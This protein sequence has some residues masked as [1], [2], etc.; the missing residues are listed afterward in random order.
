M[1]RIPAKV[2]QFGPTIAAA[3]GLLIL[4]GCG[5]MYPAT[6]QAPAPVAYN[7]PS[8]ALTNLPASEVNRY[9]VNFATGSDQIGAS[10]MSAINGAA[11]VMRANP[12]LI[13]TVIGSSDSVGG[14][15]GNMRLSRQRAMAVHNALLHTG[16]VPE[17][18]IETRWT[19]QRMANGAPTAS[20]AGVTDRSVEIALH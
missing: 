8:A 13:A 17:N 1:S 10:G 15:A 12:A 20:V 7:P 14:D 3:A 11:A 19:G 9:H 4:A 16:L 6:S 18:R 2:T 5:Q